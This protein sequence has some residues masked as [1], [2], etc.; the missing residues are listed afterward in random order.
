MKCIGWGTSPPEIDLDHL[1]DEYS[2]PRG[3]T[4][5]WIFEEAGYRGWRDS[6]ESRLL[7]LCGGPGT[8]KTMLA[9]RVA[10]EFLIEPDNPPAGV[11]LV[12]HFVS[13]ELPT[14]SISSDEAE[15]SKLRLAKIASDL[16][17]GILQQDGNLFNGCKAELERQGDRF[18]TNLCSLWKVLRQ[19]I[20]DC[21]TEP[22]YILIDGIDGL[23]ERL[24]KELIGRILGLM[25]IRTVKIFL[26]SRDAP[27]ISNILPNNLPKCT[28]IN[29]DTNSFVREDVESF[30]EHRVNAW[31]WDVDLREKAMKALMAKSE[32]I[33]LWASLAIENLTY[34]SSG[35]DFDKLLRKPPSRLQDVYRGMLRTLFLREESREVLNMIW[36]VALALRPLTFG[37]LSHILACIKEK[38]RAEQQPSQKRTSSEIQLR[39]EKEIRIY[40]RSSLGFLRATPDTVSIVHHTARAY[41]F[42]EYRKG[43]LPVLSKSEA[44]LAVSWGC[45][46]YLHHA[47]GDPERLKFRR[48]D[49]GRNHVGP[50]DSSIGRDSR[51]REPREMP[52]EVARKNPQ[53][54]ATKQTYLRYSAEYWFIH[55][56]RSIEISKDKFCDDFAHNWLQYQFFGTSDVIRKPWIELCG[57][58]RMAILVGD[59]TPL[60][61][62]VCLGLVPLVEK[63]LLDSTE[64]MNSNW[65][66]LHL[67]ARF[68]SGAYKIL[69]ARGGPSLLTHPDKNGNTPL[70]EAAIS[71][72]SSMLKALIKKFTGDSAYSNE[73]NKKNH[74]GNTP[75]HL[76]FQFDHMEI[77]ELLAK[78]GAD[79]TIKN[80]AQMTPLELGARLE[81]GNILDILKHAE[82]M[83]EETEEGVVREI[84][85]PV[86]ESVGEPV[87]QHGRVPWGRPAGS[88]PALPPGIRPVDS[89]EFLPASFSE[90]WQSSPPGAPWLRTPESAPRRTPEGTPGSLYL[91]PL[92]RR[93]TIPERNQLA[94][95]NRERLALPERKQLAIRRRSLSVNSLELLPARLPEPSRPS[96]QEPRSSS[97]P[98][99]RVARLLGR[100]RVSMRRSLVGLFRRNRKEGEQGLGAS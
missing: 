72:H 82:G 33:F 8:G 34:F 94:L 60:H 57:D 15:L 61:I 42:D 74:S 55:A 84:V 38:A 96:L 31:G 6:R 28:K 64:W 46:Q 99:P 21:Q 68:I 44:D 49:L 73:I 67:A 25:E 88:L 7:W 56:R 59:Q 90:L 23:K 53:E 37:E 22:I 39:T 40:V 5:K 27:H 70:H 80:N 95:S 20:K 79:T 97:P 71:G 89:M 100:V 81:R 78:K 91:I 2:L 45:F 29:L 32:G 77:V 65:S 92:R 10:A 63:V 11:K 48:G 76:A 35:P 87:E 52:W 41:L 26:S 1:R 83:R 24:C 47:F 86:E 19:A 36:G 85:E 98:E 12:F 69:I 13:P 14:A 51:E 3:N 4:G 18:F 66:P 50:Q 16:L 43:G 30:I 9:K 62:A 17:Y 58:S 93:P 75:L 54:A